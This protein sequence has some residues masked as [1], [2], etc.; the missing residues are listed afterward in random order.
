MQE[1]ALFGDTQIM[2]NGF[3]V[4]D[5]MITGECPEGSENKFFIIVNG[6]KYLVKDS[7]FNPRRKQPSLAPYCEYAGSTFIRLSGLLPCQTYYLGTYKNRVVVICKDIFNGYQFRP[8]R[9]LHQSSAGTDLNN[10]LYTYD[11]VLYVLKQKSKLVDSK[12]ADFHSRFWIMFLLD[13]ILG[14]RDR[15]EGNWGFIKSDKETLMSPIFDNGSSIFPDVDLSDWCNYDFIKTRVYKLPGSQF[16][17][18]RL[19]RADKPMRTNY[20]EI[21]RDYNDTF[22]EELNMLKQINIDTLIE[23]ST[24]FVPDRYAAWFRTIIKFRY[25]CLIIG[26]DYDSVWEEYNDRYN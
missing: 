13:A 14:N 18:W 26:R 24:D 6:E 15:H 21:I 3:E 12:F 1:M 7:S 19:D 9:D 11:D 23:Q 20:Y 5:S 22:S 8:F 25:E 10:K 17:M 4:K 2:R 16:K